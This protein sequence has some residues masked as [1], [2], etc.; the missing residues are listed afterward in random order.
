MNPNAQSFVPDENKEIAYTLHS[1]LKELYK[2]V[3]DPTLRTDD[4]EYFFE[5]MQESLEVLEEVHTWEFLTEHFATE[6]D[7]ISE[8]VAALAKDDDERSY[9][10]FHESRSCEDSYK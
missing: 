10:D 3:K 7:E 9:E 8:I 2:V 5:N 6:L 4:F 1:F